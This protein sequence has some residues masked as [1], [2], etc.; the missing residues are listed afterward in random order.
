[1]VEKMD[2]KVKR[3]VLKVEKRASKMKMR[4][5]EARWAYVEAIT[6]MKC[7]RLVLKE[8]NNGIILEKRF[9]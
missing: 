5:F 6:K 1:M 3:R 8:A 4:D 9:R 2:S 7:L